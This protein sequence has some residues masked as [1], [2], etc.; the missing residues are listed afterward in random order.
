MEAMSSLRPSFEG[1]IMEMQKMLDKK[2]KP[3]DCIM[4]IIT[5]VETQDGVRVYC[6]CRN[7]GRKETRQF[8][9]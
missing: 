7:C 2:C 5:R 6:K 8:A 1:G 4:Q 9:M 3:E